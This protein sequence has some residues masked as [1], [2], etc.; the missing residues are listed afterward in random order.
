MKPYNIEL[1]SGSPDDAN[2]QVFWRGAMKV[3]QP[4]IDDGTL[5]VV[6]GQ[7]DIKAAATQGWSGQVAQNR[8]DT[9]L[10]ANYTV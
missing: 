5:R 9:L 1:F 2:S 3:L 8:M 6:S 4:K 7:T 10:A